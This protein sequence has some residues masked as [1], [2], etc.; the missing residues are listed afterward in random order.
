MKMATGILVGVLAGS[1]SQA[2]NANPLVVHEWGTITTQHRAD[3]T[4]NGHLNRIA[5]SEVLPAFVH[6]FEPNRTRNDPKALLSK[7]TSVPGRP[8]VTMRLETPVLYFYPP[9]NWDAKSTF[10]VAVR[11]RGGVVNEFYPNAVAAVAMDNER[12]NAKQNAGVALDWD[13]KS[14]DNYI[15]G[16]LDWFSIKLG[17]EAKLQSTTHP[18]WLAPRNVGAAA[19]TAQGETEKFLFYRGVAHLSALLQ[20]QVTAAS[21]ELRAPAK[22]HWLPQQSMVVAKAWLIDVQSD[23]RVAMRMQ[24]ELV[25]D[26]SRESQVLAHLSRFSASDYSVANAASLRASIKQQ[27]I[28]A[29]LFNDEAEAMLETWRDSYFKQP[30]MRVLYMVPTAWTGYFLPVRISVPHKLT[31]VLVG[32]IDLLI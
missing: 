11:F 31:R 9:K 12:M 13:G 14:L 20:T 21:V 19:V 29:G 1:A 24:D 5:P 25:I 26:K 32:R 8:D 22:L 18:E 6:R 28:A 16:S 15:I 10:D 27:L 3:G 2:Q 23:G 4:P 30:G 7:G 17:A